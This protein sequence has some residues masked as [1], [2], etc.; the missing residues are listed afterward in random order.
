MSE[1]KIQLNVDK[2]AP[3][4]IGGNSYAKIISCIKNLIIYFLY[5]L[6]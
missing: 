1:T 5:Y 2:L 4:E 3:K 6:S